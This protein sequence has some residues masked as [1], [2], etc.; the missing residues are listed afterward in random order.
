MRTGF[1]YTVLGNYN[2]M[3][4]SEILFDKVNALDKKVADAALKL[5]NS[6]G[7]RLDDKDAELLALCGLSVT[8][9]IK[10]FCNVSEVPDELVICAARRVCGEFL[11]IKNSLG[12]LNIGELDL[13]A[14]AVAEIT[15]GDSSVKFAA[16]SSNTQKLIDIVRSLKQCGREEMICFRKIKW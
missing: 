11:E 9:Y 8:S 3:D 15:E 5:L 7:Y 13:S 16:S 4:E 14:P 12:V 2:I 1:Y 10:N 6:M